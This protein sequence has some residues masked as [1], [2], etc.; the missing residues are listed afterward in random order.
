[1]LRREEAEHS[2]DVKGRSDLLRNLEALSIH[3]NVMSVSD[4][5][6]FGFF[7]QFRHLDSLT[8]L[9]LENNGIR[10]TNVDA[11]RKTSETTVRKMDVQVPRE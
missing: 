10:I 8:Q 1:M 11:T 7:A 2:S 3:D 9:V 6:L 4:N 5:P